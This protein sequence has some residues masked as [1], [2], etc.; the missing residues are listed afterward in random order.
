MEAGHPQTKVLGEGGAETTEEGRMTRASERDGSFSR[1]TD[2]L[3]GQNH[4]GTG[5]GGRRIK[6][7]REQ[8]LE[9][10]G[11]ALTR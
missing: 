3:R 9:S 4:R 2:P 7:E 8:R 11:V 1:Q 10:K 5:M 6:E